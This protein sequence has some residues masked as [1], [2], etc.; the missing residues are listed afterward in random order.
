M[1]FCIC[2]VITAAYNGLSKKSTYTVHTSDRYK[3]IFVLW[4]TCTIKLKP[5]FQRPG[6]HGNCGQSSLRPSYTVATWQLEHNLTNEIIEWLSSQSGEVSMEASPAEMCL[7]ACGTKVN[8]THTRR[9][10]LMDFH[11]HNYL[12]KKQQ[13]NTFMCD[14]QFNWMTLS[15]AELILPFLFW[16]EFRNLY[17]IGC[18]QIMI[19][20]HH[21]FL[22]LLLCG[23][24]WD[25]SS[26]CKLQVTP[27]FLTIRVD[28]CTLTC[29]LLLCF[30]VTK[31][32]I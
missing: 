22:Q 19:W 17:C 24:D 7:Y 9:H 1:A 23:T 18:Y 27:N 4:L 6:D 3:E 2:I 14:I 28:V 31:V 10:T 16:F 8:K 32:S 13:W 20:Y 12:Y 11:T 15:R 21:L 30:T 25:H 29:V 26:M 5:L